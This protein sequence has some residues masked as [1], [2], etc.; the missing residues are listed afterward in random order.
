MERKLCKNCNTEKPLEDMVKKEGRYRFECKECK[1]QKAR[2]RLKIDPEFR[3]KERLR[4]KEKYEKNKPKHLAITKRYRDE[5]LPFYKDLHLRRTYGITMDDKNKMRE[6][7]NNKCAICEVAFESDRH[8]YVDHC[9]NTNKVRGLLCHPCN[10]ALGM[11][12]DNIISIERASAYLKSYVQE[13]TIPT[14]QTK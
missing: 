8:A 13:V 5:N 2:E 3:E 11:F 9:H 10:S 12:K 1:N 4:G 7:Q 6:S 14:T